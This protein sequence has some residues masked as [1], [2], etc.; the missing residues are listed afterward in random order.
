MKFPVGSVVNLY[1]VDVR[2]VEN[3]SCRGCFFSVG[4]VACTNPKTNCTPNEDTGGKSIIF[5]EVKVKDRYQHLKDA[6]QAGHIIENYDPKTGKVHNTYSLESGEK[7]SW[8]VPPTNYRIVER[9]Q[10]ESAK[11]TIEG[12]KSHLAKKIQDEIDKL[13]KEIAELA[14]K[15]NSLTTRKAAF[16][17]TL[18]MLK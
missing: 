6:Y 17:D 3:D 11:N 9:L 12:F 5:K 16:N 15:A 13:D 10:P 4:D 7:P 2:V 8:S 18:E 1:G 14:S